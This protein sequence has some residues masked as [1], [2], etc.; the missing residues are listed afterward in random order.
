[1][2]ERGQGNRPSVVRQCKLLGLAR[3]TALYRP[4][5]A[6]DRDLELQK[7]IDEVYTRHPFFGS[8]QI[9]NTLRDEG[10]QVGRRRI[11]RLMRVMGLE[12]LAP[13]PNTSKPAKGHTVYPYLMR[14][15]VIDQPNAAWCAD[16]TYI[17]VRGGFV[18]MVAIMDWH[19]RKIL[20]WRLSNTMDSTF[21]IEALREAIGR[22][23]PP[24]V[25]NTDQGAQFTSG[26]WIGVL[27][28][29]KIRISMDGKGR[30]TDN[31]FIERFWR[32]LKYEEVYLHDYTSVALARKRIADYVAFY[33]QLR[34]HQGNDGRAPDKVYGLNKSTEQA[35]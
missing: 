13:K 34:P 12:A 2:I 27:K 32:S 33:N 31:A 17:R 9:R 8:R 14:N 3:S 26:D 19:S 21:C 25:F 4:K 15:V 5:E 16:I 30:A 28:A 18:Y 1:M 11:R 24:A 7:R 22:Y 20:A 6:S 29:H 35:A 10:I 23:G